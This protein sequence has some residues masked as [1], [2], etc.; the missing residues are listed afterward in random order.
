MFVEMLPVVL[1]LKDKKLAVIGQTGYFNAGRDL[2]IYWAD[3]PEG[4]E[5]PSEA[6]ATKL[7]AWLHFCKPDVMK[8]IGMELVKQAEEWERMGE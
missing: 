3:Y 8:N 2:M 4:C 1:G 5:D 6:E 7:A